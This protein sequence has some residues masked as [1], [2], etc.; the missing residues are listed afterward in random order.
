MDLVKEFSVMDGQGHTMPVTGYQQ[1]NQLVREYLKRNDVALIVIRITKGD[2][3][4]ND[5]IGDTATD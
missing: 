4:G 2:T 3:D 1:A 5:T